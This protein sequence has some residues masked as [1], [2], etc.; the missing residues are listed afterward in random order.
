[1]D[2]DFFAGEVGTGEFDAVNGVCFV[3][4]QHYAAGIGG[5]GLL[6]SGEGGVAGFRDVGFH[7]VVVGCHGSFSFP[8][9]NCSEWTLP[10]TCRPPVISGGVGAPPARRRGGPRSQR[11]KVQR[12]GSGQYPYPG[13]PQAVNLMCGRF[14]R[15]R[16]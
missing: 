11:T 15:Q 12:P 2:D 6:K 16:A 14:E 5:V 10:D 3:E 9:D 4:F 1:V 7:F 13:D 8:P